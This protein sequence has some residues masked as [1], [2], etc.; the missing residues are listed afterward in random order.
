MPNRLGKYFPSFKCVIV[1]EKL[2]ER[3]EVGQV[4][5][6]LLARGKK[7]EVKVKMAQVGFG[8]KLTN[9]ETLV[10]RQ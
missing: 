4:D 10:A 2:K 3:Q 8:N 7:K 5:D 1:R 6:P 9:Y